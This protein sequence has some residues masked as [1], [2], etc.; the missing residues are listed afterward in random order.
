MEKENLKKSIFYRTKYCKSVVIL[1]PFI[2]L[3][4][5]TKH[6]WDKESWNWCFSFGHI[7]CCLERREQWHSIFQK[8]LIFV[9][10]EWL[11]HYQYLSLDF[12][13]NNNKRQPFLCVEYSY[14]NESNDD[15]NIIILSSIFVYELLSKQFD[16]VMSYMGKY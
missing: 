12:I 9:G 15:K 8:V 3:L 2:I 1:L 6:Q 5:L 14:E 4:C 16:R 13:H 10:S 11:I 7:F